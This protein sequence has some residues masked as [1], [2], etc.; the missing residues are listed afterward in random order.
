MA[1][2]IIH[3]SVSTDLAIKVENLAKRKGTTI[4]KLINS[5]LQKTYFQSE[6]VAQKGKNKNGH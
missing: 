2:S 4:S 1:R 3:A 5:A 6:K